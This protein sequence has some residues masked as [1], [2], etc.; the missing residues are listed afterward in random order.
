MEYKWT[1]PWIFVSETPW[2][3]GRKGLEF[4]DIPNDATGDEAWWRIMWPNIWKCIW[5]ID[6][7]IDWSIDRLIDRSINWLD[8]S[9]DRL[10]DWIGLRCL[11]CIYSISLDCLELDWFVN[12]IQWNWMIVASFITP[13]WTWLW[14]QIEDFRFPAS[15][16]NHSLPSTTCCFHWSLWHDEWDDPRPVLSKNPCFCCCFQNP[17]P[18]KNIYLTKKFKNLSCELYPSQSSPYCFSHTCEHLKFAGNAGQLMR[19]DFIKFDLH[20]SRARA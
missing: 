5:L 13:H 9:I 1:H 17:L 19:F 12:W 18:T 2:I 11:D 16:K 3:F 20:D 15:F 6:W 4:W 14:L 7:L 8:R 10:I